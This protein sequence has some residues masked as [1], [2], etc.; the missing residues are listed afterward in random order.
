MGHTGRPVVWSSGARFSLLDASDLVISCS[1]ITARTCGVQRSAL[2]AFETPV[3]VING[4]SLKSFV[5]WKGRER[6]RLG[7]DATRRPGDSA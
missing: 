2:I 3:S 4:T 6:F 1:R 5:R 7:D